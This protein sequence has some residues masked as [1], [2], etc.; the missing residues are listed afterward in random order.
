MRAMAE[1]RVVPLLGAGVNLCDRP[2]GQAW[3]QGRYLPN[4]GELAEYLAGI[5]YFPEPENRNLLRVSQYVVAKDGLGPLYDEL[6][7]LFDANYPVTPVHEFFA[8]V[9]GRLR[10]RGTAQYQV[11]LTTNYDDA[12]ERAFDAA[13]EPYDVIWYIA[14]REPRGKFW[15]RPPGG[16]EPKVIERPNSY[17]GLAIDERTVILKI[18]GAVDRTNADRDSY[19]ITED[20]YIDYLTKTDVG[21]LIPAELLVKLT[22]SR[23]LFLGYSMQDWNL[24]VIL[25]RIWGQQPLSYKSW[26]IQRNPNEIEQ[27]LWEARGVDVFDIP[28]VKYVTELSQ[29]LE[30]P[31]TNGSGSAD[32]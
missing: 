8:S 17:D 12:L 9:P 1:G 32:S 22:R 30:H 24:R 2:S 15:H 5:F 6:R 23:F 29:A 31:S 14:D 4:G 3:E 25:H 27:E 7:K 20:H 21:Q 10:E 13:N 26:A 16:S 28:L 11:I 19:V 18:H